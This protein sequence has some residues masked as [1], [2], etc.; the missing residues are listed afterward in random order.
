M[1]LPTEAGHVSAATLGAGSSRDDVDLLLAAHAEVLPGVLASTEAVAGC[2]DLLVEA[3]GAGGRIIYTGAGTSGWLASLDAAEVVVTYGVRGRVEFVVAGG[4][5]LDPASMTVG[6]DDETQARTSLLLNGLSPLD[7]LVAVS[8]S[9]STPFTLA[10]ADVAKSRGAKVIA[11]TNVPGSP[12][13][14][15]ANASIDI[16][17]PGELLAGST[18]LT[19][20]I[21]QKITLNTLSTAS[22]IRCGRAFGGHMVAVEPLNAKLRQRQVQAVALASGASVETAMAALADAEDRGDVALVMIMN[23]VDYARADAALRAVHGNIHRA[24]VTRL[25]QNPA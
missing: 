22:M 11:L 12:L 2:V 10:A 9:G 14:L 23:A 1:E 18:R 5:T 19:A 4:Q 21:T 13:S 3:F 15:L 25:E 8:A 17:I 7:V 20:G 6:D 24:V 16:A